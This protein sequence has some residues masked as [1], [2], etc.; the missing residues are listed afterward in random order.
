MSSFLSLIFNIII[1]HY[2]DIINKKSKYKELLINDLYSDTNFIVFINY[3]NSPIL[4]KE[5]DLA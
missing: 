4:Q 3:T 1:S 2:K 5:P